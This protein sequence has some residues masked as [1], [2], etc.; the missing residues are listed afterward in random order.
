[1]KKL[2]IIGVGFVVLVFA[3]AAFAYPHV[4]FLSTIKHSNFNSASQNIYIDPNIGE[5]EHKNILALLDNS[6][7]RIINKYGEFT[8][9]PVIV[10]TGTLENAKKYG[11]EAFPGRAFAA[12]WEQY[13]V[14][15]YQTH[16]INLLAHELMHAQVRKVLGYWAYLTKI[17]TWFDEGVAM[18]VDFRER[19]QVDY[20]SFSQEE[21][22]RVKT[23]SSPTTFWTNSREQNLKNYRAAKA[24][25]QKMLSIY[26]PEKLYPMLLRIK[27][28][29]NFNNVFNL[30]TKS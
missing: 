3:G 6:K 29:E 1:M 21:I 18:Q 23:L 11:L 22:S 24:A 14:I 8:A 20:K 4:F 12:P 16:D 10:V 27:Q 5:S 28:G 13:V 19:Y 25:V 30:T 15:N 17:P 2:T 9:T 7:E 26:Q